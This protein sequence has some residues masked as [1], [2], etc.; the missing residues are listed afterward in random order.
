MSSSSSSR[1]SLDLHPGARRQS[2]TE[3][4]GPAGLDADREDGRPAAGAGDDRAGQPHARGRRQGQ[5]VVSCSGRMLARGCGAACGAGSM[6]WVSTAEQEHGRGVPE[7]GPIADTVKT[8][9]CYMCACRCGIRVHLKDGRSATSRAIP[10]IRSIGGVICGKGAAGIMQ[11]HSPA[12]LC[13]PAAAQGAARRG[14]VQGD[15]LGGGAGAR[16]A[17]AL[18]AVRASDPR[19]PRLLHR[20]RPEPVPD[21]LVGQAVRH[22]QLRRPWRLLLGQHGGGRAVHDRRQLLGVRRARLGPCPLL[23]DVRRR[24]GPRQQPDQDRAGQAEGARRQDRGGQ[25]GRTGYSA[26]ADE[27]IGIRPGT[28]GLF[29]L[30]LVHELLRA[31]RV[32]LDYLVRADQRGLAGDRGAGHRPA[33]AS[34]RATPRRRRS[35]WDARA[36]RPAS[37][38]STAASRPRLVGRFTLPDGTTGAAGVRAPGRALPRSGLRAR[39]GRAEG[40]ASPPDGSG[41][42]P[43]SSARVAFEEPLVTST[44]PGP[45]GPDAAMSTMVGRPVAMHAMRGISAHSNGF[46]TCRALHL[47]QHAAR[48]VDTPGSWRYKSPYPAPDPAG[49]APLRRRARD[50]AGRAAAGHRRSASRCGPEDLLLDADGRPLRIDK[51]YSLGSAAGRPRHACTR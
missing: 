18:G 42:S 21:R 23:A 6:I 35:C 24:R 30:A 41:G 40:A 28:D 25:P 37:G 44:S 13:G 47:L 11:H 16:H 36:E 43:P 15:L 5:L 29:V 20:P 19:T 49:P 26:I 4:A 10:T 22:A 39:G 45:T 27:W 50:R 7:P 2:G 8:T 32:D 14:P 34:S 1:R 46:Q 38:R 31:G 48:R 33:T 17:M 51:A 12:R 9:T 3:G